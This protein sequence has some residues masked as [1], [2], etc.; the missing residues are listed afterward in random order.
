ML[1][2]LVEGKVNARGFETDYISF[3]KGQ[4]TLIMIQGLNTN[5]I[6]GAGLGLAFAYRMFER[7]F[8]VYL[9]D[10]RPV[11]NEGITVQEMANDIA[12]AMDSLKLKE[13]CVLG[14]SQG[15]MIAQYLAIKRPDLVER[16]VLAVTLSRTNEI[17]SGCINGWIEMTKQENYKTLVADMAEKMYSDKYLKKYRPMLP[18]LTLMQKPKDKERFIILA[19]S[20]L[21]CEA[22]SELEKINCPTLVIGGGT[23]KIVGK[24]ASLEIA[25]KLNCECYI[26]ENLGH[27]CYEEA[28][29][30]NKRVY[31]FY[32][33]ANKKQ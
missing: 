28:T 10:R 27:A 4:K 19:K 9:F 3:G 20:C 15:G 18:L 22:Y 31:E 21:S 14:V 29:D 2:N 16:M 23:D 5:G 1:Y 26:Y 33:G 6:K 13:A 8:R 24:E 7:D 12:S 25:E 11:L 32:I 30:F 17:V